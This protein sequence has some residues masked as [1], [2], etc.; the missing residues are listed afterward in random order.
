MG[1]VYSY[2]GYDDVK[3][4]RVLNWKKSEKRP[5]ESEYLKITKKFTSSLVDLTTFKKFPNIYDQGE[6]GSCTANALCCAYGFDVLNGNVQV[7]STDVSSS[8]SSSSS[9]VFEPSRLYL[10]YK[11][12]EKEHDI[13]DDN[14]AILSD[15]IYCLKNKGVCSEQKWP[16]VIQ[17]FAVKPEAD[18]DTEAVEHK[19]ILSRAVKQTQSDIESCLSAGFPVVFGFVVYPEI[20]TLNSVDGWVL[21]LPKPSEQSIGGHAVVIVGFNSTTRLFKIRNSWGDAWGDQ[22]HFYMP[23]DY[24]LNQNL[25]S[26]FWLLTQIHDVDNQ[27]Q[28]VEIEVNK[29]LVLP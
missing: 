28:E 14:G 5:D 1:V 13:P 17:K 8:S 20:Q 4:K 12:R 26:D 6:L 22:G 9:S 2:M 19:L 29:D 21:P 3:S 18:C 23:Y 11:E 15:G 27:F 25:A 7:A 10:Y 16:Y 24:V